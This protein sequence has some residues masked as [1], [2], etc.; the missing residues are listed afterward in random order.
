ME[1]CGY[2]EYK[3]LQD[4]E[5][6]NGCERWLRSVSLE[7]KRQDAAHVYVHPLLQS[8]DYPNLHV[9]CEAKVERVLFDD[10]KR[11]CGIEY[12]PN[13]EYQPVAPFTEGQNAKKS[14]KA[15]KMVVVSSG[16]C[17]TPSVLERSGIGNKEVLQKAGVE[18]VEDLP[19]MTTKITILFSTRLERAWDRTKPSIQSIVAGTL[20]MKRLRRK[21]RCSGGIHVT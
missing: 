19:D 2:P 5:S 14:V 16:A 18:V 13:P 8:G 15:R 3:D 10:D 6:N 4:L 9:L 20:G 11:A 12:S 7:G 21:S 17:H 1:R